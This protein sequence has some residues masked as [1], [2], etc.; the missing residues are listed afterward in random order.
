MGCV[1]VKQSQEEERGSLQQPVADAER[2][3]ADWWDL[4]T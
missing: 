3:I 1:S 2:R 4:L